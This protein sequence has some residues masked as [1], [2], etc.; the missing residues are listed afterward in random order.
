MCAT[1]ETNFFI[2]LFWTSWSISFPCWV[3]PSQQTKSSTFCWLPL[4]YLKSV[5]AWRATDKSI[6]RS[7][8][9]LSLRAKHEAYELA[10]SPR[11]V[12]TLM[13]EWSRKKT[14]KQKTTMGTR[15]FQ[16]NCEPWIS[17]SGIHLIDWEGGIDR[18]GN[19][20][21]TRYNTFAVGG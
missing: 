16:S 20:P 18:L 1:R 15:R 6:I 13:G 8:C 14:T 9:Y 4:I 11:N 5:G 10:T 21:S 19:G 17:R 12:Y 3:S 7:T 2:I